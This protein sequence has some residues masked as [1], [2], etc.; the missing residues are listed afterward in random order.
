MFCGMRFNLTIPVV[1]LISDHIFLASIPNHV[2][3]LILYIPYVTRN[4][5]RTFY[6]CAKKA[7]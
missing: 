4:M 2:E 5:L 7:Q 6:R 3:P 1:F